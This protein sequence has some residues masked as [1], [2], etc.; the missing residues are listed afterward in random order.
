MLKAI[1]QM[2]RTYVP[3]T[4][5]AESFAVFIEE[6]NEAGWQRLLTAIPAS[7]AERQPAEF[8]TFCEVSAVELL[9]LANT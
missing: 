9:R 8:G 6:L 5:A 7:I 2:Y 3:S 4:P 1:V